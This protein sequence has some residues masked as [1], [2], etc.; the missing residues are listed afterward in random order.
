MEGNYFRPGLTVNLTHPY[1][2]KKRSVLVMEPCQVTA[3]GIRE[4]LNQSCR[5]SGDIRVVNTLADV[6]EAMHPFPANLLVME[7]CGE[8]ESVLDGLKFINSCLNRWQTTSI[9]VCTGF[10]N[11][12]LLQLLAASGVKGLVLKQEPAAALSQCLQKVLSGRR[13]ISYKTSQLLASQPVSGKPLTPRELDVLTCLFSGKSV[14]T[15][16]IKMHRDTRTIST[17]KRNAM[18]KLGIHNDGELYLQGMWMARTG[19]LLSR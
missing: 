15:A 17:H 9:V 4:A 11:I 12:R 13:S 6:S 18:Q 16:A 7:L 3:L 1:G 5:I 14:T 8:E 19:P 2:E 10:N